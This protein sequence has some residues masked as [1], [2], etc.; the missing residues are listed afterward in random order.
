MDAPKAQKL[1][2][3]EKYNFIIKMIYLT[4]LAGILKSIMV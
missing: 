3:L 2:Y 4:E 1:M